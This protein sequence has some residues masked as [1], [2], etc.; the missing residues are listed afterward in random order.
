MQT[1]IMQTVILQMLLQF[2]NPQEDPTTDQSLRRERKKKNTSIELE[3]LRVRKICQ[4][5]RTKG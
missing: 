4:H 3:W 2:A 1:T 5:F